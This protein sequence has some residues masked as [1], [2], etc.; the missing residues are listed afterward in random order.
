MRSLSSHDA[1]VCTDLFT[2]RKRT[3]GVFGIL[4]SVQDY[5]MRTVDSL[6]QTPKEPPVTMLVL[7]TSQM[8]RFCLVLKMDTK[9]YL[10]LSHRIEGFVVS[11]G[12]DFSPYDT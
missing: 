1:W 10:I 3:L 7:E 4:S 8:D 9:A 5:R 12:A 6:E 2:C 11:C